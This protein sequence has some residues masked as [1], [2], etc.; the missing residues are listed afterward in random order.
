MYQGLKWA[1]ASIRSGQVKDLLECIR[2]FNALEDHTIP[3][4]RPPGGVLRQ[5]AAGARGGNKYCPE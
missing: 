4:E 1:I 3:I 5:D 2:V